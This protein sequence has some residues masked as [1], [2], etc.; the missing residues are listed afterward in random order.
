MVQLDTKHSATTSVKVLDLEARLESLGREDLQK[1]KPRYDDQDA[2]AD[3]AFEYDTSE[4]FDYVVADQLFG[5]SRV[6]AMDETCNCYKY[7]IKYYGQ[8]EGFRQL[9]PGLVMSLPAKSLAAQALNDLCDGALDLDHLRASDKWYL[10]AR[11]CGAKTNDGVA[12]DRRLR[13]IKMSQS[14]P[15]IITMK[16]TANGVQYAK[17][18]WNKSFLAICDEHKKEAR[19]VLKSFH[20]S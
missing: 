11:D 1:L 7:I 15:A 6:A 5:M 13:L 3:F 2:H 14:S 19:K 9:E 16:L 4:R 8:I 12:P 18:T 10:Q 20:L 17:G